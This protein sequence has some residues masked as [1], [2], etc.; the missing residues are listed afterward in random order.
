[1]VGSEDA[2]LLSVHRTKQND[3]ESVALVVHE[4]VEFE[5]L[6]VGAPADVAG[7]DAIFSQILATVEF[8]R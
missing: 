1:V 3:Y 6:V 4:T 5:V 2:S 7:T 8:T